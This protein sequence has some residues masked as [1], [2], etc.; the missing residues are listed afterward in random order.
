METSLILENMMWKTGMERRNS[1]ELLGFQDGFG[2]ILP[3]R[4]KDKEGRK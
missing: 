2:N 3:V 4:G 1:G